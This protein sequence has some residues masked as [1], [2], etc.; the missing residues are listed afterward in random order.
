MISRCFKINKSQLVKKLQSLGVPKNYYAI[1]EKF[2]ADTYVLNNIYGKW[3][4]F[5]FDERG[6][7]EGCRS[8]SSENEA[9]EFF[10]QVLRDEIKYL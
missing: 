2:T 5:Y 3:E 6:N 7:R 4:Y 10:L 9:C 1:N 8:F